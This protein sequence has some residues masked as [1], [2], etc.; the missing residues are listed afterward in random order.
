MIT[1]PTTADR[2]LNA[3][4]KLVPSVM[5]EARWYGIY[6]YV[7]TD[8]SSTTVDAKPFD[9]AIGL[10]P[11]AKV[12]TLP[13]LLGEIVTATTGKTCAIMFLDGS[14]TKPVCVS[15]TG[16]ADT[17][18]IYAGSLELGISTPGQGHAVTVEQLVA[19][20]ANVID[21]LAL[22]GALAGPFAGPG[23]W[24][25][26]A[27]ATTNLTT[28]LLAIIAV[29]TIPGIQ[30]TNTGLIGG[31]MT[32]LAPVFN[33]LQAVLLNPLPALDPTGTLPGLGRKVVKL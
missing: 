17:S 28:M 20:T 23:A 1:K 29:S 10:P 14:P 3:F 6:E 2:L 11:V 30:C 16:T 26:P 18:K 5:P 7:V 4:R 22:N 8:S 21:Y 13:S 12:P 9:P 25:V 32:L 33:A 15:I 19:W 24:V 31:D 27:V